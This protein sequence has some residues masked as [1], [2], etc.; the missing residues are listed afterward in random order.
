MAILLP[1]LM[2]LLLLIPAFT[3]AMAASATHIVGGDLG[4]RYLGETAPGTG[5]Y[6]Y[7]LILRL[8]VNC[9]PGSSFPSVIDIVGSPTTGLPVGV[10]ADDPNAPNAN[11]VRITTAP[12]YVTSYGVITPDLS[13]GC[14]L[15]DGQCVE[16][17]RLEGEVVLSGSPTGFHLYVQLFA[18]NE[19]I[20]NLVDPGGTG[21]GFY[22]YVPPTSIV[23]S[24]P[25]F[26]GTPVP[27]IC[28]SDTTAFSNAAVDSDG[29]S[30]VFSFETPYASQD[31][32]GGIA[33]PP[34]T[35][36]WPLAP[37][38]FGATYS[39]IAP[40]GASGFASINSVTGATQYGTTLIGNWVVAVEVKEY[41]N[42]QL[43]GVIRSDLQL[44]SVP[45]SGT[46]TA[47]MPLS[48]EL[49]TSY[50]VVA[51]EQLCFP[52]DFVDVDGDLMTISAIGGIFES[53]LTDPPA[54]LTGPSTGDSLLTSQFCWTTACDQG[55]SDPYHF[56]V[57]VYDDAC[58]PGTYSAT[59]SIEVVPSFAPPSISGLGIGC[60]GQT[61][62]EYCTAL[63][64]NATY[65]W[66]VTGGTIESDQDGNCI[67][68]AWGAPGIGQ[69]TV[70]RSVDGCSMETIQPVN[71]LT[72]PPA[73]FT[74]TTDTTCLGIRALAFDTSPN[75]VGSTWFVNGVETTVGQNGPEFLLPFNQAN[76]IG[77]QT[78]TNTGCV[79]YTEQTVMVAPY[80][81]LVH[82]ELPNVFTPNKD[83]VNDR[84][85]LKTTQILDPCFKLQVFDR[86][87]NLVHE[88]D[89]G[90]NG[91]NGMQENGEPASE[92]V[93]FYVVTLNDE[94]FHGHLSLMR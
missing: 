23:N 69:I 61:T 45:C 42:G 30:L 85:K 40:F 28:I 71:I 27:Y 75:T 59:I 53:T 43:I 64:E 57:L 4:Y 39:A 88:S 10:Y 41:R 94:T 7:K 50:Q 79:G 17:S 46:N 70:E 6:R 19:A 60:S 67:T 82:F 83:N 33:A 89:G 62:T 52:L 65:T 1:R 84:F 5:E 34:T 29:D 32:V 81:E 31:D 74:I 51:G 20:D 38:Q 22:S 2:R 76:V 77:L 15:G 48:G 72:T 9:G 66:T 90:N 92:G 86:W 58:P 54:A 8:F 26:T 37:V 11:K 12:V 35:L 47:P 13:D 49:T 87:G 91:W 3:L 21:M 18:R 56:S 14:S 16:E 93:Y 80:G 68:I 73:E 63:V 24:S 25:V 78:T 36:F 55:S 44:L